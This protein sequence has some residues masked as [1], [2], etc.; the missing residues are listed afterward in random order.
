MARE[1]TRTRTH[2]VAHVAAALH[3]RL[4]VE[5]TGALAQRAVHKRH[6]VDAARHFAAH[7]ERLAAARDALHDNVAAW[8]AKRAPR[9][10]HATLDGNA[11]VALLNVAGGGE[12]PHETRS[13]HTRD[14]TISHQS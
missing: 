5:P 12:R 7:S 1:P 4:D 8:H 9:L 11:I 13:L 14:S 3:T 10:V 6:V 2:N